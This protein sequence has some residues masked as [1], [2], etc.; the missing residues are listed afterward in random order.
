MSK[1]WILSLN[2]RYGPKVPDLIQSES[3][4][5]E[6]LLAK[7]CR[8]P[9]DENGIKMRFDP[10]LEGKQ[11]SPNRR[12][13]IKTYPFANNLLCAEVFVKREEW[14]GSLASYR[15]FLWQNVEEAIWICV[16]NLQKQK[17]SFDADRL[18]QHLSIVEGEFLGDDAKSAERD[19]VPKSDAMPVDEYPEDEPY[20]VVIQYRI[21]GNGTMQDYDRRVKIE[22]LL[23]GFLA[24][25]DLGYL[26]GGDIGSGAANIFCFLKPGQKGTE[27]II[28]TLRKNGYLEGAVIQE[29]VKGEEKVVWPPDYTGE[30]SVL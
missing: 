28:Q 21:E 3:A 14:E 22:T 2:P 17:I 24:Q 1:E 4:R 7:Y 19:A 6:E 15:R 18:R 30:F 25:A 16:E 20:R 10:I 8:G 29:T 11:G 26:D 23:D 5:L 27:A 9:Y 13:G 12:A